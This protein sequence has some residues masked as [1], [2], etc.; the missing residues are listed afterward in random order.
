M[1]TDPPQSP[2]KSTAL[3]LTGDQTRAQ[4][5]RNA[6]AAS[7]VE[8]MVDDSSRVEADGANGLSPA[9]I[10]V[11]ILDLDSSRPS[12]SLS[13]R[14]RERGPDTALLCL[15]DEHDIQ[16]QLASVRL[17]ANE[18]LAA[19]A[20]ASAI[21]DLVVK[22]IGSQDA[23]ARILVV[24]DEPIT[25]KVAMRTL[26][27]AGMRTQALTDPEGILQALEGFD[28]DLVLM[29]FHMP[30]ANGI[31]LTRIIRGH[32]RF[33]D[34]P[35]VFLSSEQNPK[36]QLEALRWGGDDFLSK[37]V[38]PQELLS[39]VNAKLSHRR[40]TADHET[41]PETGLAR[42]ERL[43][44]ALDQCIRHG[45]MR[46]VLV[47]LECRPPTDLAQLARAAKAEA[48]SSDL[49]ARVAEHA[50]A[51]LANG[52]ELLAAKKP[53]ASLQE[54]AA[55]LST[56]IG[57][58]SCRLDQGGKDS[59]TLVSRARKAAL[60]SL[61][62]GDGRPI[63]YRRKTSSAHRK[64]HQ[65]NAP[66]P[67]QDSTMTA[68]ESEMS[69]DELRAGQLRLLY[70]PVVPVTG[71][72]TARYQAIPR[73]ETADGDLLAP[74]DYQ[75]AA[76]QAGL[77]HELDQRILSLAL[78]AIAASRTEGVAPMLLVPQS[79]DALLGKGWFDT[80]RNAIVDH[81]LIH[82]PPAIVLPLNAAM[83]AL[84]GVTRR[85]AQLA[86]LRVP[87]CLDGFADD[88][89]CAN[90][91]DALKPAYIRLKN[92]LDL[93]PKRLGK[94]VAAA[95]ERGTKVIAGD[96]DGPETVSLYVRAHVDLIQGPYVQPA[97]LAMDFDFSVEE[98]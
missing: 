78:N 63:S 23:P 28:P 52:S 30:G 72:A 76:R 53:L 19:N 77:T 93:P 9:A 4:A 65:T 27:R 88:T 38:A 6:L 55:S 47:Y 62:R 2:S 83:T 75:S 90:A 73:L 89:S 5:L 41:D 8:L 56:P 66:E 32:G 34:L 87:L 7:R 68:P 79:F 24:D 67:T 37:P 61:K 43:F 69:G 48:G 98:G 51:I 64:P 97:G 35:V 11:V 57:I 94:L 36:L 40:S 45:A 12:K 18:S 54:I 50:I 58:G 91:L 95:Q 22:L 16:G 29:D 82:A 31:E 85:A 3:F 46:S 33:A 17:G 20:S 96:I 80:L 59:V 86:P 81:N 60:A 15:V 44:D 14:L 74:A 49:V 10:S 13:K 84:Q 21:A 42:R 92:D 1:R 25:A 71:S 39:T 26:E 70:Q